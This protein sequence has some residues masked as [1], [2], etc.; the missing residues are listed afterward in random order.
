MDEVKKWKEKW[1]VGLYIY[2]YMLETLFDTKIILI[3]QY[4]R[5]IE[6]NNIVKEVQA[7]GL[8]EISFIW[9]LDFQ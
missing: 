5:S 8:M 1:E 3:I 2:I 6:P 4:N 9:S 7:R